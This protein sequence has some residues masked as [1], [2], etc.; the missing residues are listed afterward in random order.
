V[1]TEYD[2]TFRRRRRREGNVEELA[3]D[4]ILMC[5]TFNYPARRDIL[6]V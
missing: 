1:L 5:N 4:V 3:V 2:M 6:Y